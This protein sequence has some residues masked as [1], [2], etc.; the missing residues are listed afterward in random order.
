MKTM[1]IF[2]ATLILMACGDA[3]APSPESLRPELILLN[4]QESRMKP[5]GC[6]PPR[7]DGNERMAA[8]VE[9][10]RNR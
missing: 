7:F 2:A 3:P 5:V 10:L 8:V 4:S 6:T 1:A 9:L